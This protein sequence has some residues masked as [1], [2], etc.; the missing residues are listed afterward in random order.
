MY[1]VAI[2]ALGKIGKWYLGLEVLNDMG[3][4]GDGTDKPKADAY[5]YA[6]AINACGKAGKAIEVSP[7]LLFTLYIHIHIF[8]YVCSIFFMLCGIS[9]SV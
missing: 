4:R 2:N 8:L 3:V 9:E 5:V 7:R 1:S 6:A